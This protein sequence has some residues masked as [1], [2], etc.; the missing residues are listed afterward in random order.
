LLTL[1]TGAGAGRNAVKDARI[2]PPHAYAVV[3]ILRDP[4]VPTEDGTVKGR[5]LKGWKFWKRGRTRMEQRTGV[6]AGYAGVVGE[7][8]GGSESQGASR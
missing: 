8:G 1:G 4:D 7:G 6:D 5:M 2:V 3:D